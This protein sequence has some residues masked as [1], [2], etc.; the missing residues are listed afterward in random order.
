M[1]LKTEMR[2]PVVNLIPVIQSLTVHLI[3]RAIPINM[4]KNAQYNIQ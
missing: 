4:C 2:L 1:M 3:G